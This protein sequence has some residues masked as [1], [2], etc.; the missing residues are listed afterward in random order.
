MSIDSDDIL[1]D[2]ELTL[3]NDKALLEQQNRLALETAVLI[4]KSIVITDEDK[5]KVEKK[6]KV[7]KESVNQK[8]DED[9]CL[10]LQ[11]D[12]ETFIKEKMDLDSG[13][14]NIDKIPTGID[15]LDAVMGGGFGVGTFSMIVGL[16][17][18]FKSALL[19]QVIGQAQKKYNGKLLCTYHDSESAMTKERLKKLGVINPEIKPY[20]DVTVESIFKT[21]EAIS[22]FK[23]LRNL[24]YPAIV[25]WDSIINTS[26]EK[27]RTT[28]DITKTIGLRARLLSSL[29]PRYIPKMKKNKITLISVNQLREKI[30]M[31]MMPTAN[32]LRWMGD[33]V[34]PGGFAVKFNAFHLLFLKVKGDLLFEQYGFKGVKLE[35]K[36]I[37]NKFF[38][39]NVP[40]EILVDFNTGMSNFWTNYN[41]LV[42]TK[43]LQAGAWNFLISKPE[44]KFRTIQALEM[45][46]SNEDGFKDIFDLEVKNTIETEILKKD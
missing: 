15:L 39:P 23:Q 9:I 4:E 21:I 17:G 5:L 36:C 29:F 45:Y 11:N 44:K 46:N 30:D 43:R 16:P 2:D 35:A 18:T 28:D 24:D 38:M 41:F 8:S 10:E 19:G 22:A 12:L 42:T 34:I 14:A 33:K 6:K 31:G 37:K 27:E 32:D 40:I 3:Q 25:A 20:D 26:T 7:K 13:D 1:T